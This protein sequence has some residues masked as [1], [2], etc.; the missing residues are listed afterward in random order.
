[1]PENYDNSQ[2]PGETIPLVVHVI[3]RLAIGGMENGLVNLI[4]NMP[5]N[6]YRH[7]IICV[8]DYTDFRN[9]ITVPVDIYALHK[10]PGNNISSHIRLWRLLRKLRPDIIHTRNLGTLEY[11]LVA[12]LAGVKVT[13]HG[14]HGR[15]M[16]DIDGT[17]KKYN[18]MRRLFRPFIS[19]YITVSQDLERWL[20]VVINVDRN[21]IYQIYNGVDIEKFSRLELADSSHHIYEKIVIGTIGR[22]KEEKDQSTLISAFARL[23]EICPAM[24]RRLQLII[25][26]DGPLRDNLEALAYRKGI[27][28]WVTFTG[29]R[30]DVPSLLRSMHIFVL[31]SLGEGISNT[32]L[33]AMASGLPVVATAVGG[34]LELVQDGI[35]GR[36]VSSANVNEMSDALKSYIEN[37]DLIRMH[38][39]AGRE[40]IVSKFLINN[41]VN[42][43]MYV[44]DKY[45]GLS[46]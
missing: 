10:K 41:M 7:A 32:I 14:E 3:Y 20:E 12:R 31:P 25:V 38:G 4:N 24:K 29:A 42:G 30:D 2:S 35:T 17:S 19:A 9:R 46:V 21:N 44:Y 26:G 1:M 43:Y 6:R 33:E 37:I 13:I 18:F 28:D 23:L 40:N 22:L 15:D 45:L 39:S 11:A 27:S 36:L 5:V 16:Q 34:N 8:T